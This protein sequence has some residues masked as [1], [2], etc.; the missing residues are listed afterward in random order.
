MDEKEKNPWRPPE[1]PKLV[2]PLPDFD[3]LPISAWLKTPPILP[4]GLYPD[5]KNYTA[6]S[7]NEQWNRERFVKPTQFCERITHLSEI[8][9][10]TVHGFNPDVLGVEE[11]TESIGEAMNKTYD[12]LIGNVMA[13][14]CIPGEVMFG[15][16]FKD[17]GIKE[18]NMDRS[19]AD[20]KFKKVTIEC[21]DG[22][23]YAGKVAH[24]CGS[25]YRFN[26][27]C[28]EAMIE[29]KPIAAYGI[30]NVIFQNPATI[31]FWSDGTKTVVNC[32]DNA[33]TKKKI[34]DGKEVIIRKPRKCDT[35]SKE[36]GLA[37]AIV[38]KWAGNNGNY[39]NIFRKFIPE[40]AEEEKAAKKAK[41]EQKAEK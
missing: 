30:E 16:I 24:I 19:L 32:M 17:L 35:Y 39:N 40:M 36:A 8:S 27:L 9:K 5:E 31:V 34:V 4:K 2:P 15:D 29:D 6:V 14:C 26:N 20:K 41:K 22:S 28:V 23:T 13:S 37:M 1:L 7:S 18:D 21:E 38:K 12:E 25:P 11:V 10:A 3:D 33:E